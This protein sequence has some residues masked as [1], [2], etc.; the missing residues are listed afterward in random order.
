MYLIM[1]SA[2]F[3][4]LCSGLFSH[5]SYQLTEM[6]EL[7]KD[8]FLMVRQVHNLNS[9]YMYALVRFLLKHN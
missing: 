7:K 2:Y 3:T 9:W 6:G 4:L 5:V 1:L 8:R